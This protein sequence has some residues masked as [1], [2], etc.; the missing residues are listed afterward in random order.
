M[1]VSSSNPSTQDTDVRAEISVSLRPTVL[2]SKCSKTLSQE[3][4]REKGEQELDSWLS[5]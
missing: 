2:H 4:V 1:V 5:W 3:V